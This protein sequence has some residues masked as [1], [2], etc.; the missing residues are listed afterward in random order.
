MLRSPYAPEW[1]KENVQIC[2]RWYADGNGGQCGGGAAQLLC[3]P[4]GSYTAEYRDDIDN[5]EAVDVECHGC[6]LFLLMHLSGFV[7]S[8]SAISGIQMVIGQ[9]G[10]GEGRELCANSNHWTT[11]YRDDT[12]NRG[13][14]CRM[15]WELRL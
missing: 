8:S 9:C 11:Y 10:A 15:S 2:Y 3:A 12:D 7:P 4:I 6:S 14:G 13:G 5:I 1:F